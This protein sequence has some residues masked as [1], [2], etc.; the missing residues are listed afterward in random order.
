M[1]RASLFALQQSRLRAAK[2]PVEFVARGHQPASFKQKYLTATKTETWDFN[3]DPTLSQV[4]EYAVNLNDQNISDLDRWTVYGQSGFSIAENAGI[5]IEQNET[6]TDS[7]SEDQHSDEEPEP[8]D[9]KEDDGRELPSGD[10]IYGSVANLPVATQST[11]SDHELSLT[12]LSIAASEAKIDAAQTNSSDPAEDDESE[13]FSSASP[14]VPPPGGH[15]I[16]DKMSDQLSYATT[17]DLGTFDIGLQLD[18][19]ESAL[20]REDQLHSNSMSEASVQFDAALEVNAILSNHSD[21]EAS[22]GS[23]IDEVVAIGIPQAASYEDS[24][25]TAASSKI[26]PEV[27]QKSEVF[28]PVRAA[29]IWLVASKHGLSTDADALKNRGTSWAAFGDLFTASDEIHAIVDAAGLEMQT[30]GEVAVQIAS[31]LA[32]VPAVAICSSDNTDRALIVTSIKNGNSSEPFVQCTD[33]ALDG[34]PIEQSRN[35]NQLVSDMKQNSK[36]LALVFF[37]QS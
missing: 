26:V 12:L 5:E 32:R 17:F 6:L 9:R 10:T 35:L 15:N 7:E 19:I 1:S 22:G 28:S 25:F 29:A 18:R 21:V 36:N 27:I 8:E 37:L 23:A 30:A 13:A 20:Q 33:L 14:A 2:R 31:I 11:I 24:N 3:P 34:P 16:F 4:L